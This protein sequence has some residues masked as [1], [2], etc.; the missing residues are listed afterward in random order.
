M[1]R[2]LTEILLALAL[3]GAPA[4]AQDST[5]DERVSQY[6]DHLGA[7]ELL[8]V[9]LRERLDAASGEERVLIAERLGELYTRRL[10]SARSDEE[11]AE[12]EAR[13][14]ALLEAIPEGDL[15][16]LR[17]SLAITLYLASEAVAERS[18]LAMA[19]ESEVAGAV[20]SLREVRQSLL[21]VA[22]L[23]E[24]E[25]ALQERR[26]RAASETVREEAGAALA[27]ARRVRSLSRYYAGWAGYYTALLEDDR[28]LVRD[29]VRDFGYLL[30]STEQRPTIERLPKRLLHYEHVSR[31]AVGV[32]LCFSLEERHAEAR[33]WLDELAQ[34]PEFSTEAVDQLRSAMIVVLARG[35]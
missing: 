23:T 20:E 30:D 15:T 26:E 24:R 14:R 19:S 8:G 33:R 21:E 16:E 22:L 27:D 25:I 10:G 4:L 18:R 12:I 32:A 9:Q 29:A 11:R 5:P 7:D 6:L 3:L 28:A 13:S 1:C 34:A 31:A 35:R 17:L 2:R